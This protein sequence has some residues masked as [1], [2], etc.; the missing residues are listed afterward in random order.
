M[1]ADVKKCDKSEWSS[2]CTI[3]ATRSRPEALWI[4][5]RQLLAGAVTP[6]CACEEEGGVSQLVVLVTM[7][8]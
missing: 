8:L 5:A 6:T 3:V 1:L 7:R 4:L 2:Y